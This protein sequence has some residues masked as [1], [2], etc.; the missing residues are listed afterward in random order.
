MDNLASL[1]I[2]DS[3]AVPYMTVPG[4]PDDT[5]ISISLPDIPIA[6]TDVEK[7]SNMAVPDTPPT[8]STLTGVGDVTSVQD[9]ND[10]KDIVAPVGPTSPEPVTL[11]DDVENVVELVAPDDVNA[12]VGV[13]LDSNLDDV[14]DPFTPTIPTRPTDAQNVSSVENIMESKPVAPIEQVTLIE[15]PTTMDDV[16]QVSLVPAVTGLE[17]ADPLVAPS[18]PN[19]DV[20]GNPNVSGTPEILGQSTILVKKLA[21][22]GGTLPDTGDNSNSN[23]A[24]ELLGLLSG[25]LTLLGIKG[26]KKEKN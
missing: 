9:V 6:P 12:P 26:L 17:N 4:L 16:N 10:V 21:S 22:A 25:F 2:M 7:P 14:S 24:T 19:K 1:D 15:G 20:L 11:G 5:N 3:Q 23:L 8:L 13:T 18:M